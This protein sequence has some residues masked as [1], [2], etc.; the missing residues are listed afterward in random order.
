MHRSTGRTSTISR[1]QQSGVVTAV[2]ECLPHWWVAGHCQGMSADLHRSVYAFL[3]AN[4]LGLLSVGNSMRRQL[5][6]C[7]REPFLVTVLM[8]A[9]PVGTGRLLRHDVRVKPIAERQR[10]T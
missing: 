7:A 1:F 2:V 4:R 5:P 8:R 6:Q 10:P 3:S 9:M